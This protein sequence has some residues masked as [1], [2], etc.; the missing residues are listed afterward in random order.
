MSLRRRDGKSYSTED[1]NETV[2]S[3]KLKAADEREID[4][5]I[6]SSHAASSLFD[7][8]F[9]LSLVLGGCCAYVAVFVLTAVVDAD[10][11]GD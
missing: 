4:P 9:I 7:F 2:L 3:A 6:R 10:I 8:S 11:D 1:A 5:G